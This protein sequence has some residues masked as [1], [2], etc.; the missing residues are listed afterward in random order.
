MLVP[1]DCK[2][3]LVRDLLSIWHS[4]ST[5]QYA[6]S[7]IEMLSSPTC[8]LQKFISM[9][10]W[11]QLAFICVSQTPPYKLT[12][13]LFSDFYGGARNN[14]IPYGTMVPGE[15]TLDFQKEQWQ[16]GARVVPPTPH[17]L[18]E[19]VSCNVDRAWCTIMHFPAGM[20]FLCSAEI[21]WRTSWGTIPSGAPSSFMVPKIIDNNW[22]TCWHFHQRG[23]GL[24]GSQSLNFPLTPRDGPFM[25]RL[26]Q[27]GGTS[28]AASKLYLVRG[29]R[30]EFSLWGCPTGTFQVQ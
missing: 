2:S 6:Y 1:L 7:A 20:H 25:S 19:L 22:L 26:E 23:Q 4:L 5:A 9:V 14:C 24:N 3:D 10:W 29:Y 15:C 27:H 13:N 30:E 17:Q 18:A 12:P 28:T 21:Y 11:A 8:F 16:G